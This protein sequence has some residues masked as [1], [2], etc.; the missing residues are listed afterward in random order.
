M[1][2]L[3]LKCQGAIADNKSDIEESSEKERDD[4]SNDSLSLSQPRQKMGATVSF[5]EV[6]TRFPG[7]FVRKTIKLSALIGVNCFI[8]HVSRE[9][10]GRHFP[11][12]LSGPPS[13]PE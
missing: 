7:V 5:S 8:R 13:R 4:E 12:V 6:R 10:E 2:R 11:L 9:Q 3:G 1:T